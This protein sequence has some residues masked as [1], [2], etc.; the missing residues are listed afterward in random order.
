MFIPCRKRDENWSK[1]RKGAFSGN[2]KALNVP[3]HFDDVLEQIYDKKKAKNQSL[4]TVNQRLAFLNS[5]GNPCIF[6]ETKFRDRKFP[7]RTFQDGKLRDQNIPGIPIC[8]GI[9][10]FFWRKFQDFILNRAENSRI[11]ES[12]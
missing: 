8:H 4:A 11:F 3:P 7:D 12:T 5:T 10:D 1:L 2:P 6:R 9:W